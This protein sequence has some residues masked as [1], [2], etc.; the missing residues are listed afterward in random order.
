MKYFSLYFIIGTMNKRVVF[1][2]KEPTS[3]PFNH[4][5]TYYVTLSADT[6]QLKVS[7]KDAVVKIEGDEIKAIDGGEI[8]LATLIAKCKKNE[9]EEISQQKE[10]DHKPRARF[11]IE[12]IQKSTVDDYLSKYDEIKER[13]KD[14]GKEI[15]DR[16]QIIL[17]ERKLKNEADKIKDRQT[18]FVLPLQKNEGLKVRIE[19]IAKEVNE[20]LNL[21]L[22]APYND[23]PHLLFSFALDFEKQGDDIERGKK[24]TLLDDLVRQLMMHINEGLLHKANHLGSLHKEGPILLEGPTG[25]G[26]TMFAK[27]F[28]EE[29]FKSKEGK[30][31]FIHENVSGIPEGMVEPRVRG[32]VEGVATDVRATAGCFEKAHNGVLFLD[33]FQN[34]K[35]WLQTQLL[36]IMEADS[37]GVKISRVGAEQKEK[38]K[39][40]C[41]MELNVKT[42]IA[43][44]ERIEDLKKESRVREDLYYRIRQTVKF[45]SLKELLGEEEQNMRDALSPEHFLWKL[46]YIYRWDKPSI[47]DVDKLNKPFPDLPKELIESLLKES[48]NGNFREFKTRILDIL[49]EYDNSPEPD[50]ERYIRAPSAQ[51]AADSTEEKRTTNVSEKKEKNSLLSVVEEVL[52]KSNYNYKETCKKLKERGYRL[53]SEPSLRKFIRDN[54]KDFSSEIIENQKVKRTSTPPASSL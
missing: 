49:W 8:L 52:K 14:K 32:T 41:N 19:S 46:I 15:N 23:R 5:Y 45:P 34:A 22:K 37:N 27:L 2:K 29:H 20:N 18:I 1:F 24:K 28:Y 42:F 17:Q 31:D 54:F 25:A 21:L 4:P 10:N 16:E 12:L 38:Y 36:D 50:Y 9:W 39:E 40:Y 53:G 35:K 30:G 26:K 3:S 6:I 13:E 33:E 7:K 47:I 11:L 51:E 44:N 48:W 43:V